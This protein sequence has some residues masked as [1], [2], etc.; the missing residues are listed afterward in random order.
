M[1]HNDLPE[2]PTAHL[3]LFFLGIFIFL[4]EI[5][6]FFLE[7]IGIPWKNKVFKLAFTGFFSSI[8]WNGG[9]TK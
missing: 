3:H 4:R 9:S 7:K 6:S 5:S 2:I 1:L 8:F